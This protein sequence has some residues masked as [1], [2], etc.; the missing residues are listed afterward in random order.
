MNIT[1]EIG[2]LIKIIHRFY[3]NSYMKELKEF[4]FSD[5]RPSFIDILIFVS[6]NEGCSIKDIGNF[7]HLK[8][9][10]MTSH[11][12]ELIKRG[13]IEKAANPEDKRQQVITFTSQ[14]QKFKLALFQASENVLSL[15]KENIGEVELDRFKYSLE[16]FIHH[17]K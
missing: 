9:Q 5:L 17:L 2:N 3:L 7:C 13:Y 12:N 10:T 14:G 15:W 16:R 1:H 11:I 6:Y 4:G 8:K